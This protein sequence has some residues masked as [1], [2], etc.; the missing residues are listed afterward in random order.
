MS[1]TL[2]RRGAALCALALLATSGLAL[3]GCSSQ[4]L[5][6]EP[7]EKEDIEAKRKHHEE[8]A[9]T[10]YEGGRYDQAV[11]QWR[12]VL[13]ITPDDKRAKWGFAK[14]MAMTGTVANLRVA[15]S[16]FLQI[17]DLDWTH[18]TRGNIKFELES[19]LAEV[20]LELSDFYDKDVQFLTE[21]LE[22]SRDP[23][24]LENKRRQE[25]TRDELL[26]RSI[27]LLQRVLAQSPDN[28]RALAGLAKA[29]LVIGDP[30]AGVSFARRYIALSHDSQ[31]LRQQQFKDFE[32]ARGRDTTPEQRAFFK[33]KI[34]GARE[35]ELGMRLLVA[36][37]LMRRRDA[38]G[39]VAE[40]DAILE[41]DPARPAAYVE[42][43][44]A[45]ALMGDY[46]K[47][48]ADVEK[49]LKITDPEKHHEARLKAAELLDRYR[50]EAAQRVGTPASPAADPSR[51]R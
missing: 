43:A 44:Q 16:V 19:D 29:N 20:Y 26:R 42:R 47:A 4:E 27:P 8:S 5:G 10:F 39:A 11:A 23:V 2:L 33:D 34:R 22:R 32:K 40:Y 50:L 18:P 6:I 25:Q 31:V 41:M 30:D 21:K 48:I 28:P 9:M 12:K 36:S 14:A 1:E 45:Y 35:K 38:I 3:C 15:E 37:V 17:I 7:T 46:R 49:Y 24:F 13:E 51:L